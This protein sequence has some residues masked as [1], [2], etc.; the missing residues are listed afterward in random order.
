MKSLSVFL[1]VFLLTAC[2]EQVATDTAESLAA[3]SGRLRELREQC[4]IE[5]A[6]LGDELCNAAAEATRR[7][8]MGDGEVPYTPPQEQPMF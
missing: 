7:R 4:R 1:L 5:Q 8:F 2:G 6:K 3:D